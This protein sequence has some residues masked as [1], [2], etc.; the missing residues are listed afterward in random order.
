MKVKKFWI[1]L[2]FLTFFI[3]GP[4]SAQVVI[5]DRHPGNSNT[6]QVGCEVIS[7]LETRCSGKRWPHTL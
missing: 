7:G 1:G 4:G 5:A 3:C 2:V 6:S